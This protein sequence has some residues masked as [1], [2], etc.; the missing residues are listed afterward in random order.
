MS[1]QRYLQPKLLH[2]KQKDVQDKSQI[3]LQMQL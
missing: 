2:F 3:T 1:V